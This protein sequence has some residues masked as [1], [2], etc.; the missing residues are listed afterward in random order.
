MCTHAFQVGVPLNAALITITQKER[1]TY[2]S[3]YKDD[4]QANK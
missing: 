2:S 1:Y 4:T 3:K